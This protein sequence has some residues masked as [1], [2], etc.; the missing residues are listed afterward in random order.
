MLRSLRARQSIIAG[1]GLLM[2][3]YLG[4]FG[5]LLLL[6]SITPLAGT[7]Y[8][9]GLLIGTLSAAASE[10]WIRTHAAYGGRYPGLMPCMAMLT[11]LVLVTTATFFYS[12]GLQFGY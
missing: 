11:T 2:A 4:A 1:V 7:M 5:V 6:P 8:L 10:I 3:V 9:V 12:Q